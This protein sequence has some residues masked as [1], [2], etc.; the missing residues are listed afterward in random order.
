MFGI[1]LDHYTDMRITLYRPTSSTTI[2]HVGRLPFS[3]CLTYAYVYLY[4]CALTP[5][6][7]AS[8]T[9]PTTTLATAFP[10]KSHVCHVG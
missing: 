5:V 3:D 1:K 8:S 10:N 2:I 4:A 6:H 7:I 9:F